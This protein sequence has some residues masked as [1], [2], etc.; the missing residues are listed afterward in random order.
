MQKNKF[1]PGWQH[2]LFLVAVVITVLFTWAYHNYSHHSFNA[3]RFQK[4]LHA[5]NTQADEFA[6]LF[7]KKLSTG[8][9]WHAIDS[10]ELIKPDGIEL[11]EKELLRM[12]M[13]KTIMTLE[14]C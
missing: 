13:L 8:K 7:A 5:K 6:Q 9:E 12:N 3:L 11:L 14:P 10:T 4:A 2:V 1:L